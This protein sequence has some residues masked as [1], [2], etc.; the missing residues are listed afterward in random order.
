MHSTSMAKVA[1][2]GIY[3]NVCIVQY[4]I[5]QGIVIQ[6]S[7]IHRTPITTGPGWSRL[8]IEI[9]LI[10]RTPVRTGPGWSR[11][12]IQYYLHSCIVHNVICDIVYYIQYSIE[13]CIQYCSPGKCFRYVLLFVVFECLSF[14]Y[15][16]PHSTGAHAGRSSKVALYSVFQHGFAN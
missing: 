13:Y 11:L 6:I 3:S 10:H 5:V 15:T 9:S 12:H 1:T 16:Y 8:H 14:F 2:V 4:I 7:L